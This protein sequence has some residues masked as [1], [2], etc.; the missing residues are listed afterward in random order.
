MAKTQ[1]CTSCGESKKINDF[2][3]SYSILF[4]SNQEQRMTVCKECIVD[5]YNYFFSKVNIE[6]N[7]V[8]LTCQLFDSCFNLTLFDSVI[9]QAEKSKSNIIQIYF[10]K[11]NSLHQYKN[12]TFL[13]SDKFELEAVVIDSK[14]DEQYQEILNRDFI[15]TPYMVA[16]WGKGLTKENMMLLENEY[17]NL[18]TYYQC[19]SYAQQILFQEISHQRLDIKKKR[20]SGSNVDK[21]MKTLQDLLGSASIKPAQQDSL[22]AGEQV[23]FTTLIDEWEKEKPI[24]EP[25]DDF[26]DI[27]GIKKYISVWFFGHLCKMLGLK[28]NYSKMYDEEISKYTVENPNDSTE[29]EESGDSDG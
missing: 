11:I 9:E 6:I 28:N 14:V 19:D 12:K 15:V 10:Q 20:E 21:E 5:A 3:K 25:E 23:S 8:Y 26:K 18:K 17:H 2:Y 27:D 24:P 1:S 4:K 16:F 7:A 22:S 13:D 29:D